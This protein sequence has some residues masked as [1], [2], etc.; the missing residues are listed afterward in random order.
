MAKFI[1][2]SRFTKQ[3]EEQIST[4]KRGRPKKDSNIKENN[5]IININISKTLL[6]NLDNALSIISQDLDFKV[7]RSQAISF[8]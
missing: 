6:E 8:S 2:T 3:N 5:A 1:N 7:N 4:K